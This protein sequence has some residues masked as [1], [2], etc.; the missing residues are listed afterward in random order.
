MI[1][2]LQPNIGWVIALFSFAIIG[3]YPLGSFASLLLPALLLDRQYHQHFELTAVLLLLI[4]ALLALGIAFS[5]DIMRATAAVQRQFTLVIL[6]IL[7]LL[8]KP[9]FP[10]NVS[11]MRFLTLGNVAFSAFCIIVAAV[12]SFQSGSLHDPVHET[13]FVYNNFIHQNL[14]GPIGLN[15]AYLAASCALSILW[16]VPKVLKKH[17]Y[18]SILTFVYLFFVLLLC[19][20]VMVTV[21]F[22]I[23]FLFNLF[24]GEQLSYSFH[25]LKLPVFAALALIV[26]WVTATKLQDFSLEF[27]Y[28]DPYLRPLQ[29]RL[30]IWTSAIEKIASEPWFGYG[31]GDS[32]AIIL[33]AYANHSF[34]I[35][36]E[37][38]FNAHNQFLELWLQIGIAGPLLLLSLFIWRFR[39]AIQSQAHMVA[40]AVFI[41]FML[42]L[43]ESVLLTFRGVIFFGF[44]IF[45]P[46]KFDH[47]SSA[48]S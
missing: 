31:T 18:V 36:L 23:A 39:E 25:K 10:S 29:I 1:S 27:S 15:A 16:L 11:P 45:L 19:K 4:V 30:G 13:H 12:K 35:G 48:G 38:G 42:C 44:C 26:G 2:R 14:T 28:A 37:N 21:A 43:T 33:D 7:L 9:S 41:L 34:A 32:R 47:E 20:S 46:L 8:R 17:Q 40:S 5:D 22:S 24:W 6:A 3:P